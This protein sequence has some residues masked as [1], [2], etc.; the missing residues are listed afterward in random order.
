[1]GAISIKINKDETA[2]GQAPD[3]GGTNREP[4]KPTVQNQA[5]NTALISAGRQIMKQGITQYANLTG[6][7]A[8][9]EKVDDVLSI[10]SDIAILA[11][12]PVGWVAVGTKQIINI[13]NSVIGQ[14]NAV[15]NVEL[16]QQR[17]G[18]VATQ[19]SR[20]RQ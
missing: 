8:F 11:T 13:A 18:Y 1:M 12:G 16:Q 14:I 9:A 2:Q 10:G 17:A 15:R 3:V 20:Y 4:G 6:N 7:Y 19:G 5:V